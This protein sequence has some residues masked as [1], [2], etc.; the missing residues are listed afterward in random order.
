[1]S[2]LC[3]LRQRCLGSL[4]PLTKDYP[5]HAQDTDRF[6]ISLVSFVGKIR[7]PKHNKYAPSEVLLLS[8]CKA[9][10]EGFKGYKIN[11]I[12]QMTGHIPFPW[13]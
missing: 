13:N 7:G 10:K 5:V 1:M 8:F 2:I 12:R 3:D 11:V 4:L 9:D 6:F